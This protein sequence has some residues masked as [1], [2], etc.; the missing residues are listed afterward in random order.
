MHE[1]VLLFHALPVGQMNFGAAM[2]DDG[3]RGLDEVHRI[4]PAKA[5]TNALGQMGI[6]NMRHVSSLLKGRL[7]AV[8]CIRIHGSEPYKLVFRLFT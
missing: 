5:G 4:L 8:T 6:G 7:P 2:L 3:Q 1:A